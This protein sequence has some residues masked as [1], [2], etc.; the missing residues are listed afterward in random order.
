M[1]K[2]ILTAIDQQQLEQWVF[3]L[4]EAEAT[5]RLI[6]VGRQTRVEVDP[7]VAESVLGIAPPK[8]W[9]KG[10]KI[11]VGIL[12]GMLLLMIIGIVAGNSMQA[13][14]ESKAFVDYRDLAGKNKAEL[15]T[16]F[17]E[18][19][20]ELALK[21]DCPKGDCWVL[22]FKNGMSVILRADQVTRFEFA[23]RQASE[24]NYLSKINLETEEEPDISNEMVKRWLLVDG[25]DVTVIKNNQGGFTYGVTVLDDAG[26]AKAQR[27]QKIEALFDPTLGGQVPAVMNSIMN[28]MHDSWSFEHI[29]TAYSDKGDPDFIYIECAFRG[30]NPL[31][32]KVMNTALAKVDLEGNVLEIE[33]VD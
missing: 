12:G 30:K 33:L 26:K 28:G 6:P 29:R 4:K 10:M 9:S 27:Q 15:I 2:T 8:P 18:P 21:E 5:Y 22:D 11:T 7:D 17:G 14:E 24:S 31:G 20:N 13:A 19:S 1:Q 32:S 16:K 23:V 25:L 3:L